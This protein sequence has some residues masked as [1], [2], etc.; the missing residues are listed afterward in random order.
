MT[1]VEVELARR[2]WEDGQR[3]FADA[4][5]DGERE[6]S[7]LAALEVVTDELRRRIGQTFTLA[8]L[9][10]LYAG[11]ETWVRAAIGE[12][13]PFDGWPRLATVV[14]DAAFHLY[15]RGAV[16]YEP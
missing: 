3:R 15:S 1:P 7:L 14:Q 16:D 4:V 11:A 10:E 5:G 13:A 9:T 8:E 12:R 2:E 6:P